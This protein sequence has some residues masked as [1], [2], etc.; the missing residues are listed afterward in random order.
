MTPFQILP[1]P[2]S[3][4]KDKPSDR[5]GSQA[6]TGIL[7]LAGGDVPPALKRSEGIFHPMPPARQRD[8]P[9][10]GAPGHG[11]STAS[12][13]SVSGTTKMGP[14]GQCPPESPILTES[15]GDMFEGRSKTEQCQLVP[16]LAQELNR[17][18]HSIG[19]TA[20]RKGDR[21]QPQVVHE[22][23]KAGGVGKQPG[24]VRM[25]T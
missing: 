9:C 15:P 12:P 5:D 20:Y 22:S 25:I 10:S 14:D 23:G 6:G 21:R 3:G 17:Y 8:A 18:G 11:A 2:D 13:A 4:P 24:D 7:L 16:G 1:S 19:V